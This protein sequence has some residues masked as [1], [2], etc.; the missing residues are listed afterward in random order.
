VIAN[1]VAMFLILV[2]GPSYMI[3]GLSQMYG[4]S[5]DQGATG[6]AWAA[7]SSFT[8]SIFGLLAALFVVLF[9]LSIFLG[10]TSIQVGVSLTIDAFSVLRE[11]VWPLFVF[12]AAWATGLYFGARSKNV[13]KL[14]RHR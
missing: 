9:T 12:L 2:P 6:L 11:M 8:A 7:L 14:E 3:F 10:V 1:Q 5:M 4:R 13:E